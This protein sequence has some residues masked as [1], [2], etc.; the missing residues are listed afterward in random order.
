MQNVTEHALGSYYG[1]QK[2]RGTFKKC[3]TFIRHS[4]LYM[5]VRAVKS[6]EQ[7]IGFFHNYYAFFMHSK[8]METSHEGKS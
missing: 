4:Y 5:F 2:L 8:N 1:K 3:A 7:K 6:E